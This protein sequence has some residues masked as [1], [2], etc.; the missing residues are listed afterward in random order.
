MLP[1][2]S[3]GWTSV[4]SCVNYCLFTMAFGSSM[5]R[6]AGAS[7][8]LV[9]MACLQTTNAWLDPIVIKG[10]RF[11][12][13]KTG[14]EFRMKGMAYYPRPNAGNLS[15]VNNYDWAADTHEDV[16]KP[17]LEVMKDLGVNVIRLYSVDPTTSHDKFMCACS[18]AGIY[19]LIGM[20]AP[21]EN[22]AILDL[23]PPKCYPD[24]LFTRMQM[25]Y[26]A[27]AVYDNTL[28]FSVGNENNLLR[29]YS[30]GGFQTAPCVKAL[31]RDTRNYADSCASAIR[32]VPIGLDSADIKPRESFIAYYDCTVDDNEFTRAEWHGFNPYVE[33]DPVK[34]TKYED[35]KGLQALMKEYN[36]T[37]YSRPI[38]FGEYGCNLG[39]NTMDGYENQRTFY[40]AKW[41]NEEPEMMDQIVGGNVFEFVTEIPNTV[42]KAL[43]K[44]KDNGR[45]GVGYF[46]P[47]TCDHFTIPCKFK[48]YP[49]YDNL[50]KAYSTTKNSTLTLKEYTPTRNNILKCPGNVTSKL[51]PMPKVDTLKCS[52]NQP[53]CN[54]KKSNS[55]RD[56]KASTA[57]KLGE[58]KKPTNVS[59]EDPSAPKSEGGAGG[60]GN[61]APALSAATS[62][63]AAAAVA[64]AMLL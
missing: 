43:T 62:V 20:A 14:V 59:P 25:V 53:T 41:M 12:N 2:A 28:G 46:D 52:V 40:D 6:A 23:E 36:A 3:A 60:K 38:M 27:F 32:R 24:E 34:H 26:N 16:W 54:G 58:K 61:A 49:E 15:D 44:E 9:A 33:C 29:K 35:S 42:A 4:F 45:Y 21:C 7:A 50:K 17:H 11:F 13:S 47:L 57:P 18:E 10:N 22:C 37:G 64:V 56:A 30:E 31:I 1:R 51:P 63:A 55:D 48:P 39:E 19:V 8:L 5:L